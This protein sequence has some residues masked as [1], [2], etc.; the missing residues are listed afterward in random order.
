LQHHAVQLVNRKSYYFEIN[1]G[2]VN[3]IDPIPSNDAKYTAPH[4]SRTKVST[5]IDI[6]FP[7]YCKRRGYSDMIASRAVSGTELLMSCPM[8]V[9]VHDVSAHEHLHCRV[10][11]CLQISSRRSPAHIVGELWACGESMTTFLV[12]HAG[13]LII[14]EYR[15]ARRR[16][17]YRKVSAARP[18]NYSC[19]IR[20][21][22][23]SVIE[24]PVQLS[25]APESTYSNEI[26]PELLAGSETA[27]DDEILLAMSDGNNSCLV[28]T[29]F[30]FVIANWIQT[31]VSTGVVSKQ[32]EINELG[33]D[34]IR[35][36][37]AE[38]SP[39]NCGSHSP[40]LTDY[41]S[42]DEII[43][44]HTPVAQFYAVE[45]TACLCPECVVDTRS[46]R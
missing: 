8:T 46:A 23:K 31:V 13:R 16:A 43:V 25:G 27:S 10:S 34:D 36:A 39:I 21:Q 3:R 35:I 4:F 29:I 2:A 40:T 28:C 14:A 24:L 5:A 30:F 7:E 11:C 19:G 1:R 9:H 26:V 18:G 42:T 32:Q 44:K 12:E 41:A 33:V 38:N 15:S 20:L 6:H 17:E 22:Q 45:Y 37:M